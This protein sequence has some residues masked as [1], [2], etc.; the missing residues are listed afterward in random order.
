M[1]CEVSKH[2]FLFSSGT[3]VCGVSLYLR[4]EELVAVILSSLVLRCYLLAM[5]C[6]RKVSVTW[7][8]FL[9]E[10]HT[11]SRSVNMS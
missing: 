4:P 8:A 7:I 9:H 5:H 11:C 3:L 2:E 10:R 1:I 6:S